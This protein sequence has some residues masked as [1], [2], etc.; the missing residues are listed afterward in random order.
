[1]SGSRQ[2]PVGAHL[3]EQHL[4]DR[5]SALVD[6]ELGHDTRERVLAHLATCA[7]CK[8]E[9]DAQRALK[10]V[11]ATAA[12]PPPSAS[13]L[14][15]LQGLPGGGDGDAGTPPEPLGDGPGSRA[16][17]DPGTFGMRRGFSFGYVPARPPGPGPER[18][19]FHGESGFGGPA[20]PLG[21]GGFR[22]HPVG[23]PEDARP[24]SRG[25]RFAFA[26]AGAVSL[27]AVALGG[28]TTAIP[29]YPAADAR[30]TGSNVI[31]ARTAGTGGGGGVTTSAESQRRRQGPLTA[32]GGGA[33]LGRTT[34]SP[35]A[36]T[37]PL[38]PGASDAVDGQP[39]DA[40]ARPTTG[41]L[42]AGVNAVTPLI[43]PLD[44]AMDLPLGKWST[45]PMVP[46]M[47]SDTG[48][49]PAPHNPMRP[50]ASSTPLV[51]PPVVPAT[52]RRT[53]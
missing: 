33:P 8:A 32:Q 45:A 35:T 51:S 47:L 28:V 42:M 7:R 17:G 48:P 9:A 5:L 21:G 16:P 14:A 23:R 18:T 26:A 36:V 19:G 1:M 6:G 24:A 40:G 13:L 34:P 29:G 38:V 11:F 2:K 41:P 27:A 53:P 25:L 49:D 10:S 15:R 12:P 31:P 52:P 30:G 20:G 46:G 50:A 39:Q 3:A 22:V 43:R 44:K 37:A 4:G